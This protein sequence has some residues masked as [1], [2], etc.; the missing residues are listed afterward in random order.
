MNYYIGF[1]GSDDGKSCKTCNTK[2]IF[3][4]PMENSTENPSFPGWKHVDLMCPHCNFVHTFKRE[5]WLEDFKGSKLGSWF[6]GHT[7]TP[8]KSRGTHVYINLEENRS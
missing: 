3:G 1:Y 5:F 4:E 8:V 2:L 6:D 7:I